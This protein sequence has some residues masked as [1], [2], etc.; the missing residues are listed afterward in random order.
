[1]RIFDTTHTHVDDTNTIH[2]YYRRDLVAHATRKPSLDFFTNNIDPHG[3]WRALSID[4]AREVM[5][6]TRIHAVTH[7]V[8]TRTHTHTHTEHSRA[9][10]VLQ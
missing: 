9:T 1:M 8:R 4:S 5:G 7:E 6:E 3:P 2:I 10:Y